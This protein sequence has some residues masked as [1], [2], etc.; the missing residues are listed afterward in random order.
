MIK[1]ANAN[2]PEL[3]ADHSPDETAEVSF[4]SSPATTL[5]A[6]SEGA[7]MAAPEG[8]RVPRVDGGEGARSL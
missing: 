8:A 4:H 5:V 7:I 1:V 6:P 2:I 3:L